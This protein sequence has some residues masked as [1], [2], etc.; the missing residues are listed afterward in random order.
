M[1]KR[2]RDAADGLL[3]NEMFQKNISFFLEMF[4]VE[5]LDADEDV[6][7]DCGFDSEFRG[8]QFGG[9]GGLR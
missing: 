2:K 3:R 9:G 4:T 1:Y 7:C 8:A 5:G 6:R